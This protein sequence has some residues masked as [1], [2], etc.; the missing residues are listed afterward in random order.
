VRPKTL[1]VD[2]GI[3]AV[4]AAG[5]LIAAPGAAFAGLVAI[6]IVVVCAASWAVE[7]RAARSRQRKYTAKKS[8]SSGVR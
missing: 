1:A 4:L 3:A 6:A 5:V 2:V 7:A 8:R